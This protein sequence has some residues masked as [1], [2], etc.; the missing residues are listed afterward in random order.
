M[1]LPW[2]CSPSV[3]ALIHQEIVFYPL[4]V[5][6]HEWN[7]EYPY[8]VAVLV[9]QESV[10]SINS[11]SYSG[12][13]NVVAKYHNLIQRRSYLFR[14]SFLSQDKITLFIAEIKWVKTRFNLEGQNKKKEKRHRDREGHLTAWFSCI[15]SGSEFIITTEILPQQPEAVLLGISR[16][17]KPGRT[18]NA[19]V[20]DRKRRTCTFQSM[21]ATT[22]TVCVILYSWE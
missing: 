20:S 2:V 21:K 19:S 22:N 4:V 18:C 5:R 16:I 8:P 17:S 11:E 3:E 13:I 15:K 1:L 9:T 7:W 10:G 6:V 14:I 12:I